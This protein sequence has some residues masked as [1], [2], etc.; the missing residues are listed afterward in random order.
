[1]MLFFLLLILLL[2]VVVVVAV[3][4]VL[5]VEAV[6][7]YFIYFLCFIYKYKYINT[8]VTFSYKIEC[9]ETASLSWRCTI[10]VE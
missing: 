2:R 1:M 6:Q 9:Y 3:V 10:I 4:V 7:W 5:I 8:G